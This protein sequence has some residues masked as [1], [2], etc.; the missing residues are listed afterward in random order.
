MDVILQALENAGPDLTSQRYVSAMEQI[1]NL[2]TAEYESVS[3]TNGP[4][5]EG[6]NTWQ[7]AQFNNGRWQPSND[8]WAMTG[9]YGN[10][11][12]FPGDAATVA[13]AIKEGQ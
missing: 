9:P 6:D 5:T 11:S 4:G 2:Q 13:T 12:D 10:W 3:F 8:L 7:T 1:Q